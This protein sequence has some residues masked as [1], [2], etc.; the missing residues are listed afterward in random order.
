MLA[1]GPERADD[2]SAG[3]RRSPIGMPRTRHHAVD[4]RPKIAAPGGAADNCTPPIRARRVV[5]TRPAL[6]EGSRP[7]RPEARRRQTGRQDHGERHDG[8]HDALAADERLVSTAMRWPPAK[9]VEQERVP[10]RLPGAVG[11]RANRRLNSRSWRRARKLGVEG[12]ASVV[13]SAVVCGRPPSRSRRKGRTAA[14]LAAPK[15]LAQDVEEPAGSGDRSAAPS[16]C[17]QQLAP[18]RHG[19]A[20]AFRFRAVERLSK[21]RPY[22]AVDGRRASR[23]RGSCDDARIDARYLGSRSEPLDPQV[24]FVVL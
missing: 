10:P 11:V 3:F 22:R 14:C 20:H 19:A 6:T 15:R 2:M 21:E 7:P 13:R 24:D 9:T 5:M 8:V 16:R 4:A 12:A 17:R 18:L 23:S 1:D